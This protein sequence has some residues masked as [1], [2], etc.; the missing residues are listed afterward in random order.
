MKTPQSHPQ[1]DQSHS[2]G[3]AAGHSRV[4]QKTSPAATTIAHSP[5]MKTQRQFIHETFGP[6]A[7]ATQ[8]QGDPDQKARS[9]GSAGLSTLRSPGDTR[10]VQRAVDKKG[11]RL[12]KHVKDGKHFGD[13]NIVQSIA[14]R[15]VPYL[16]DV[17]T[18][19]LIPG[20]MDMNGAPIMISIPVMIPEMM[21]TQP[22][23]Q[24]PT[25][26]FI[27][28]THK[29]TRWFREPYET[30]VFKNT[31]TPVDPNLP[32][33]K[34]GEHTY[35]PINYSQ[36]YTYELVIDYMA[37]FLNKGTQAGSTDIDMGSWKIQVKWL[38][39]ASDDVDNTGFTI[40]QW[41]MKW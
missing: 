2:T 8:L 1:S 24:V 33:G 5:R 32:T 17:P 28:H 16:V 21:S 9:E 38:P 31:N 37:G 15:D 26:R 39:D 3:L 7:D 14:Y 6:V 25:G 40:T 13:P 35:F 29:E 10:T 41:Y 23:L 36:A 20:G 34:V 27:Q 12:S 22:G 19:K 18:Y 4:A 30:W 11:I